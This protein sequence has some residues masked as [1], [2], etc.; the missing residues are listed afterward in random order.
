VTDQANDT[1][2]TV[3]GTFTEGTVLVRHA[4]RL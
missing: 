3:T 2:D 1:V 4:V